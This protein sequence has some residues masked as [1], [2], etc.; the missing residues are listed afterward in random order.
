VKIIRLPGCR[1]KAICG[2]ST[3][4]QQNRT[5]PPRRLVALAYSPPMARINHAG[6]K[7]GL[8][9]LLRIDGYHPFGSNND[10]SGHPL[11]SFSSDDVIG[12]DYG[13]ADSL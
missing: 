6:R 8:L 3:W 10:N 13:C 5:T 4:E 12:A 1:P 7:S 11:M 9:S 2:I